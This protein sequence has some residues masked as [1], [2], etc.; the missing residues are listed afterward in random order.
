MS[1]RPGAVPIE[2]NRERDDETDRLLVE[3]GWHS[4]RIWEYDDP[5]EPVELVAPSPCDAR[6]QYLQ[7]RCPQSRG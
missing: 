7:A 2:R 6:P 1:T 4:I 5:D 3:A